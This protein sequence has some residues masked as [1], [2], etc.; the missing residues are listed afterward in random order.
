MIR[1]LP[2]DFKRVVYRAKPPE[3]REYGFDEGIDLVDEISGS[4]PREKA[5]RTWSFDINCVAE[6]AG[7][8][9]LPGRRVVDIFFVN[10]TVVWRVE[11]GCDHKFAI[12]SNDGVQRFVERECRA[13][14]LRLVAVVV[15]AAAL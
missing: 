1:P 2:R 13:P 8:I 5:R 9:Q 11:L 6:V 7:A 4:K 10:A 3:R 15:A 12:G 14:R